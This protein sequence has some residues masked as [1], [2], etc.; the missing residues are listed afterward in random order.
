[1][2]ESPTEPGSPGPDFPDP[3]SSGPQGHRIAFLER[4]ERAGR[5][6]ENTILVSI[7]SAMIFLGGAQIVTRNFMGTSIVWA[8]E[9][10]R[11]MVLWIALFGAVAASRD[12][13]HITIDVL[14]R[15]LSPEKQRWVAAV[16]NL[17]TALVAYTL[18]WFSLEFVKGSF[19]Y[20]DQILNGYPAW[21]FQ[22]ALPLAFGLI[23]YRYTIWFLRRLRSADPGVE[24]L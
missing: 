10:L 6:F 12:D 4:A 11:L 5:F 14:A 17:F 20:G 9:A 23:G 3:G 24:Q 22:A 7:L 15:I 16:V 8:D 13:R 2:I 1:M 19:E 21:M 18:A